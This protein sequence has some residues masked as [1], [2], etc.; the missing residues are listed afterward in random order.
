MNRQPYYLDNN[1]EPSI[2]S[3]TAVD[4][5]A[6][7][8]VIPL[9]NPGEGGP[10]ADG[11]NS[12]PV[13]YTHL[14]VYKRQICSTIVTSAPARAPKTAA[15]SPLAPPPIMMIFRLIRFSHSF[16][17]SKYILSVFAVHFNCFHIILTPAR[18]P[19]HAQ[20]V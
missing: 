19:G 12:V 20:L 1:D 8:P 10:V 6:Q 9:P 14:D 2:V 15:A 7:I 13:S 5:D 16:H 18:R 4:N 3:T 11:N 17:S